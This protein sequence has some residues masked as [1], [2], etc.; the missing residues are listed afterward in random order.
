MKICLFRDA[1]KT[2]FILGVFPV[3]E[4]LNMSQFLFTNLKKMLKIF[5]PKSKPKGMLN[6]HLFL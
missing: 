2:K 3:Q 5:M 4:F 6:L 1:K